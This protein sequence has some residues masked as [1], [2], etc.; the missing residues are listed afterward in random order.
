MSI[1][2]QYLVIV[3]ND[4]EL[5]AGESGGSKGKY[6]NAIDIK[7][8]DWSV[9]DRSSV[10]GK[11]TTDKGASHHSGKSGTSTHEET[12][13]VP[14]LFK[15]TKGV[16]TSSTRLMRAMDRNER[17]QW[18]KFI[19]H[20]ERADGAHD[21]HLEFLLEVTLDDVYVVGYSLQ[22][23]AAEA[24]VDLDESWELHY[25]WITVNYKSAGGL[26]VKFERKAGTDRQN[27]DKPGKDDSAKLNKRLA[28]LEKSMNKG[29]G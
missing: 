11:K 5:I 15:F 4:G 3:G 20:E 25:E 16:D 28:L 6:R 22:G 7:N 2:G 21:G 26:E 13:V 14:D 23:R 17:M 8:W 9:I 24:R 19:L 1:A 10:A 12:G 29:G 27:D 18:A